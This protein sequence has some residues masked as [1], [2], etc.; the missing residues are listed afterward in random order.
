MYQQFDPFLNV[1]ADGILPKV[2]QIG[3]DASSI[4]HNTAAHGVEDFEIGI[5]DQV[6][7]GYYFSVFLHAVFGLSPIQ[8]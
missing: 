5:I 6:K 3:Y 4:T 7:E 8:R 2:F 1:V